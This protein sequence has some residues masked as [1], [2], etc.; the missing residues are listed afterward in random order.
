MLRLGLWV[1]EEVAEGVGPAP[2]EES[3]E[4]EDP[5]DRSRAYG[6]VE[7]S[8]SLEGTRGLGWVEEE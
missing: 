2:G 1:K 8:R 3:R 4:E 5:G 6:A 7:L